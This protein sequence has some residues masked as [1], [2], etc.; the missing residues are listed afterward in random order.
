MFARRQMILPKANPAAVPK[1]CYK[2]LGEVDC[3]D[4]E[5]PEFSDRLIQE[6]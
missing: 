6:P 5:I 4:K 3:Y 2:T 1:W